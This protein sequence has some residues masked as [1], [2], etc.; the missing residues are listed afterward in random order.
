MEGLG[1]LTVVLYA[2]RVMHRPRRDQHQVLGAGPPHMCH[3]RPQVLTE[4]VQGHMLP[5][6]VR[7]ASC[8]VPKLAWVQALPDKPP[9]LPHPQA[10]V[11]I[12]I[13]GRVSIHL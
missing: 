4:L 1:Y 3:D 12:C 9:E 11:V 13:Y 7:T 5:R 10:H 8:L 6:A 2:P